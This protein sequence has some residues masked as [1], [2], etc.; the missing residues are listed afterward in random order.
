MVVGCKMKKCP[1]CEVPPKELG[2]PDAIYPPRNLK[3]IQKTLAFYDTEPDKFSENCSNAGIKP[4]VHPFWQNLLYCNF[5]N[6]ITL[7]IL[8]QF[9]L[10][11]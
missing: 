5:F 7:D 4:I 9:F 8:H 6:A 1:E 3:E 10:F 11:I 2:E